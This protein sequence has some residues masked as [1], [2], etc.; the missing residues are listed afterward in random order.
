MRPPASYGLKISGLNMTTQHTNIVVENV[1]VSKTYRT[2]IDING[3][4]GLVMTNVTVTGVP[5]GNGVSLTDVDNAVIDGVTTSGNAWGG[6]A[7]Y[8]YGRYY[9]GGSDNKRQHQR[10]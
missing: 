7:I 9:P 6:M 8:T 2:G 4:N 3:I 5:Y 1:T 10:G